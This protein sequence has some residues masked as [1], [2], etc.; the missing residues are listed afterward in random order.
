MSPSED[1]VVDEIYA[2]PVEAERFYEFIEHWESLLV[3]ALTQDKPDHFQKEY[4]LKHMR[5]ALN[6]FDR[7]E[8]DQTEG[9][10]LH[11]SPYPTLLCNHAGHIL[12]A[13]TSA[14]QLWRV[15]AGAHINDLPFDTKSKNALGQGIHKVDDSKEPHGYEVVKLL[16][17]PGEPT[18]FAGLRRA[19]S[20]QAPA[21]T[22]VIVT[23]NQ[24][25]WPASLGNVLRDALGLTVKEC[26]VVESLSL[27]LSVSDIAQTR[28]RSVNTVRAQ[29][30]SIYEKTG[31][32]NQGELLRLAM[33]VTGLNLAQSLFEPSMENEDIA[34]CVPAAH[35]RHIIR[36]GLSGRKLDY[37]DFGDASGFPVVLFHD[38]YYGYFCTDDFEQRAKQ[39]GLRIIAMARPGF[40]FTE[41]CEGGVATE[42]QVADDLEELL[43]LLD[44]SEFSIVSKRTG[45]RY[46]VALAEKY[47]SSV[48]SFVAVTPALPVLGAHQYLKMPGLARMVSLAN[49]SNR[50]LLELTSRTG[51]GYYKLHG[52]KRF[53]QLLNQNH[54]EDLDTLED[55]LIW[56]ALRAGMYFTIANQHQAYY[57]DVSY[58]PPTLWA[59][60]CDMKTPVTC[61]IGER[62][63]NGREARAQ[64]LLEADAPVQVQMV[65]GAAGLLFHTHPQAVLDHL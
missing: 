64:A 24:L 56:P 21:S 40:G 49:F 10:I 44:I 13:N 29:I 43:A 20:N 55:D 12:W 47:S 31:M 23:A 5:R 53:A 38:E 27:G 37:A 36:L 45:L 54:Q 18:C 8:P 41:I 52:A 34:G 42:P 3:E 39:Q 22:D 33:S 57:G 6:L 19:K 1:R 59:K 28:S 50:T 9:E 15:D 62:D 35:Q 60:M 16:T 7:L 4:V 26:E 51:Y 32:A 17:S 25:A 11:G 14:Q 2:A 48:R 58:D 61:I 46:A 65:P 63:L 30:R